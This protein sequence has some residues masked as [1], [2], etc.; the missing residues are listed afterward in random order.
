[1]I[2]LNYSPDISAGNENILALLFDMNRLWEEYIY[3]ML[4]KDIPVDYEIIYQDGQHFWENR[5][6]RPD[7][8]IRRSLPDGKK[9]TYVIDTKWRIPENNQ[10]SDDELKQMYAYNLYWDAPRSMLLYPEVNPQIEKFGWFHKGRS[11]ENHCKVGF[12]SIFDQDG[13]LDRNIGNIILS[14]LLN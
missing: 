8:V 3:R 12:V 6:I 14:K 13:L 7:L 11:T 2:I 9:E 5:T 4:I 1:M 10:P